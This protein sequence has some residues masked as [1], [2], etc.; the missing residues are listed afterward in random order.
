MRL[1]TI[2]DRSSQ[3]DVRRSQDQN[4]QKSL[5]TPERRAGLEALEREFT[6]LL[7]SLQR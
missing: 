3:S 2:E 1:D 6:E 7:N 5:L 4:S